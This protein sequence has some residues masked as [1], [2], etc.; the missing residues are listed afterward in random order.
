MS[1]VLQILTRP[2]LAPALRRMILIGAAVW[3]ADWATLRVVAADAHASSQSRADLEEVLLQA[4]LFC[5]FPRVVTAFGELNEAWPT[6]DAP[7]GGALPRDDALRAGDALF[8]A[9][10]GKNDAAVRA[11]LRSG[12]GELHDFVFEAAYGRILCRPHLPPRTRE[13]LAVGLLAAQDQVRQF[14]AHARGARHFG[15]SDAEL[16]EVLV[17]V[18][19][20]HPAGGDRADAWSARLR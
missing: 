11:L 15:A 14:V 3:R 1:D 7:R 2:H 19:G 18:F 12:H 5:G 13:L 17:T 20:E 6:D 8:T 10:Y 4:I 9:I 16:R